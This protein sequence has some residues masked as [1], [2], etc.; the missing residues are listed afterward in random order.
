LYGSNEYGTLR[1]I[2]ALVKER[3]KDP[4]DIND[5]FFSIWGIIIISFSFLEKRA[6][7]NWLK[8]YG[9]FMFLAYCQLFLARG[10]VRHLF[11]GFYPMISLSILGF[12]NFR[13]NYLSF[14]LIS[15]SKNKIFNIKFDI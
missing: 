7:F 11:I 9:I 5:Y 1:M 6:M 15:F 2:L 13:D 14:S 12:Q 4:F 10:I 3:F 8:L